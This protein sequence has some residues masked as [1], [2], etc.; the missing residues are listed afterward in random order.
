MSG[1]IWIGNVHFGDTNVAV[2]LHTAV[3][4]HRVQFHL[5]HKTD[6]VKLRQQMICAF[7]KVPIPAEEQVKGYQLDEAKYVLFDPEELEETEPE[8]DRNITVREF[9]KTGEIDPVFLD[10]TYYLEPEA[11]P[12][13]YAALAMAMKGMEADGVCTWVM[14]K[15]AY[16]GA[17]H[18][19]GTSLRLNVLRHADEVIPVQSLGLEIFPLSQKELDTGS[20]LIKKLTVHFEP[21]KY[22]NEHYEKLMALI[23]KKARGEKLTLLKPRHLKA[24]SPSRLLAALEKSLKRAA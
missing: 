4:Q 14:R 17:L 23:E 21:Q 1:A 10:R 11:S 5:F 2:K 19:S 18:S 6:R 15:R 9:V 22:K 3:S 8:G 20:E 24:T 12:K 13:S 7:E 16:L